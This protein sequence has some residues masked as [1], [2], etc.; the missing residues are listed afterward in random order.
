MQTEEHKHDLP[1][2]NLL[3][4]RAQREE[5]KAR[6]AVVDAV[7]LRRVVKTSSGIEGEILLVKRGKP[8]FAGEWALP[9]GFMQ[10]NESAEEAVVREV[11]EETGVKV[12]P[13]KITGVYSSP[14]RDPERQPV[15]VAFLCDYLGGDARGGDDAGEARWWLLAWLPKL[16]FDHDRIIKDAVSII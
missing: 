13:V 16:A 2:A 12:K 5:H 10:W 15:A 8:P 3:G 7:V 11:Y 9:G 4:L 1:E 6:P 14:S